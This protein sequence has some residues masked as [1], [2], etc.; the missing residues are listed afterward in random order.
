MTIVIQ[1]DAGPMEPDFP[2]HKL[3]IIN[4]ENFNRIVIVAHDALSDVAL[5]LLHQVLAVGKAHDVPF[6]IVDVGLAA[7][8]VFVVVSLGGMVVVQLGLDAFE[9]FRLSFL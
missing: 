1:P 2:L 4:H 9:Q 7:F 5:N 8:P 6:E 3:D